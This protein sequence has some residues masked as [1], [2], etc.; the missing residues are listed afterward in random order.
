MKNYFP[1]VFVLFAFTASELP[2][3]LPEKQWLQYKVPED[4]GFS[5]QKLQKAHRLAD[6]YKSA[7]VLIIY[8]GAIVQ[9]WGDAS[10]PFRMHS[11]RKVTQSALIG[12][13][14]SKGLIDINKTIGEY[15]IDEV[16]PLTEIEKS[17]TVKQLMT[18]YSGIY[19]PSASGGDDIP[20]RG[21]HRPGE[22]WYYNNWNFNA[23]NTVFEQ[24]THVKLTDA[25]VDDIAQPI[26][27]ED[28][29]PH[30][31]IYR[32]EKF[33]QHPAYHLNISSRD[34]ARFG[35]L[36]MNEGR[37]GK[38]QV[39]P[40]KWVKESLTAYTPKT[41]RYGAGYAWVIHPETTFNQKCYAAEGS[42]G[43][44][45]MLFPE[46][47]MIIVH[48][49]NTYVEPWISV[50]WIYIRKI[51]KEIF[52]SRTEIKSTIDESKLITYEPDH[53]HWPKLIPDDPLKTKRFEKYYDNNGDPATILREKDGQLIVR[54]PNLGTYDLYS[55]TDST[56]FIEGIEEKIFFEY[57]NKREPIKAMFQ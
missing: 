22:H 32:Y 54:F 13:Y 28:F 33:S 16:T 50:D 43:H 34:M 20:K 7:S 19:L 41:E 46:S 10:R 37:W 40:S 38:E 15:G 39:I 2:S 35:M 57:N 55:I 51:V 11:S 1:F 30:D 48:R 42:G 8:K 14:A 18:G 44:A 26:G 3:G 47:D 52:A 29:V 24:Q 56:F 21:I 9:S 31:A 53:K 45:L 27:M 17:A 25:F 12:I 36:Y 23:L 4:A 6:H 5:S 49:A